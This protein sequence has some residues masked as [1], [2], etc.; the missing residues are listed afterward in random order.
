MKMGIERVL[1]ENFPDLKEVLAVSDA[2]EAPVLS[3]EA[4]EKALAKISAAIKALK[5]SAEVKE[6]DAAAG[7]VT[8]LFRG[9][10]KL[11]QGVELVIRDVP[12]VK[13]VVLEDA[14]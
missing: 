5:G 12:L 2:P 3:R 1:R 7:R 4:V 8:V 14:P 11:K 6:V 13:E 9:P 10:A